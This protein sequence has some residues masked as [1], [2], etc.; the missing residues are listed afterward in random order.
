LD[1]LGQQLLGVPAWA[2][3]AFN[4]DKPSPG[5]AAPGAF[6]ALWPRRRRPQRA[7]TCVNDM[8]TD[9]VIATKPSPHSA[10]VPSDCVECAYTHLPATLRAHITPCTRW[11]QAWALTCCRCHNATFSGC[12]DSHWDVHRKVV[13][14]GGCHLVPIGS[15]VTIIGCLVLPAISQVELP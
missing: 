11:A 8:A 14:A 4:V 5:S 3:F 1:G 9:Y 13:A 7:A 2:H 10:A 15:G 6:F 12:G